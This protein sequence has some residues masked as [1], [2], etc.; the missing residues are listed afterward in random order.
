[1]L[2][3]PVALFAVVLAACLDLPPITCTRDRSCLN[4]DEIDGICLAANNNVKYCAFPSADCPSM[5]R[6]GAYSD[7]YTDKCVDPVLVPR[8]AGVDGGGDGPTDAAIGGDGD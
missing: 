5:W 7:D 3:L 8:D 2:V 1:M 6:W 4:K